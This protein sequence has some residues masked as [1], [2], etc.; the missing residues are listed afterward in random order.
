M[1]TSASNLKPANWVAVVTVGIGAFALVTTEFLPVGLLSQIADD[2]GI[3]KGQVGWMVTLPGVLAAFAAPLILHFGR[4]LDR[5]DVLGWLL[6]LLGISNALVAVADNVLT[7]LIGRVLLGIAVGG[8]WTVGGTLGPRLRPGQAAKATSVIFAGI[9]LGTVAGVPA[10]TFAGQLLGWRE[11][12]ATASALSFIVMF[13]LI[14]TVPR[15]PAQPNVDLRS[16]KLVLD[17][18]K[19]KLAI[20]AAL[21]IFAG[22]FAAYT[23]ITPFLLSVALINAH[24]LSVMLLGFGVAGFI[25]NM[26]GGW[27][28]GKSPQS[29]LVLASALVGVPLLLLVVLP[30]NTLVTIGLVMVWGLGFGLLPTAMQGWLFTIAP[31]RLELMGALLVSSVQMSVG[32]GALLGGLLVDH[33]SLQSTFVLGGIL[34]TIA[35][36]VVAKSDTQTDSKRQPAFASFERGTRNTIQKDVAVMLRN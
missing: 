23:Y 25:G 16:L 10:G 20:A 8:F 27:A 13:L 5:R 2:L 26:F 12:F 15:I 30:I 32:L 6:A 34:A 24:A 22:Q 36:V 31:D 28:V 18:P 4:R 14:K 9:S 33:Y 17:L 19:A 1:N 29:A 11:V 35:T 21:L 3:S 7:L